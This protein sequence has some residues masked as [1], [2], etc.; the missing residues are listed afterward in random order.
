MPMGY[1][2]ETIN[3]KIILSSI[4][5]KNFTF[6]TSRPNNVAIMNNGD[7]IIINSI[8]VRTIN[9]ISVC[10]V[11]IEGEQLVFHR[12]IFDYPMPSRKVGIMYVRKNKNSLKRY[13]VKDISMKCIYTKLNKKK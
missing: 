9:N 12:D 10:S 6:A 13:Y 7:I 1:P 2:V 5:F 3:D 8:Y 4:K 11:I